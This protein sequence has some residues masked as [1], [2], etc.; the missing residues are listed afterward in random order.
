MPKPSRAVPWPRRLMPALFCILAAIPALAQEAAQA[1]TAQPTTAQATLES[2][3]TWI[4]QREAI[5]EYLRIAKVVSMETLKVGVTRPRRAVLAEGG[6]VPAMAWKVVPPGRPSGYWESYK[7]EIAAYEL[8]KLLGLN[9]VPPTVERRIQGDTGAA[10]MWCSPTKNFKEM[11]GVPTP[12]GPHVARWVRQLVR[13]KMFDNLI[14]NRDPNLG[15]WLVDPSWNL[16]LIDHT[17]AFTTEKDLVH[18][19][20]DHVDAE[21][22][23]KMKA[24]TLETL[25]PV[26]QKWVGRGEIRAM[27]ERR[28]RMQQEFEKLVAEKG[29]GVILR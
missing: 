26:L 29:E 18:K 1:T 17:R 27:L 23:E 25:T 11:G 3:L 16:I 10:V 15:N 19:K 28:D 6:L 9:M 5:E 8:D 4:E 14:G 24:L 21:L 22:W 12:P 2:A 7:S 13:A 20:M